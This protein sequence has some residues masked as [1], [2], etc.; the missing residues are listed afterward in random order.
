SW[1]EML[2][3]EEPLTAVG[4]RITLIL[5]KTTTLTKGDMDELDRL[6]T[7]R[8]RLIKQSAKPAPAPIGD[9]PADDGQRREGARGER[10]DRG[11][12]GGKKREKKVKN[13]VSGLTEVDFLDKFIS[14]M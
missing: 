11:D 6:T 2:S 13:D 3:D 5:E 12:K 8:E 4:R 9:R 7:V 10:R 1:E 14:K